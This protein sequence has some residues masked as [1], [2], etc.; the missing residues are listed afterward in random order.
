MYESPRKS[1]IERWMEGGSMVILTQMKLSTT[2]KL[3]GFCE[4]CK[5]GIIELESLW[6]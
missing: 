6:C 2:N 3:H 5:Q 4:I 1:D